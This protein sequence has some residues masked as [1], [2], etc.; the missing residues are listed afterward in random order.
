VCECCSR[1]LARI[2]A[3]GFLDSKTGRR[4][5]E[6]EGFA[7]ALQKAALGDLFSAIHFVPLTVIEPGSEVNKCNRDFRQFDSLPLLWLSAI[8]SHQDVT[9]FTDRT[10][11]LVL[12]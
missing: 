4:R 2:C 3:T 8:T 5:S 10:H 1:L 7:E 12:N 9:N 6:I 11:R